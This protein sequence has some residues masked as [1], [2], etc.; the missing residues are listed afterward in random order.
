MR[1]FGSIFLILSCAICSICSAANVDLRTT[2]PLVIPVDNVTPTLTSADVAKV[3]PTDMTSTES[4]SSVM[5]RIADK[6]FNL[7]FNSS[8]MKD[9]TLVRIAEKTQETLKTDVVVAAK[10]PDEV[11]HKFS[12]RVEAF[13]ALAKLEYSGWTKCAVNYDAKASQT[14]V[15]LKEKIFHNKDLVFSH[16]KN[17]SQGLSMIG[18]AWT[19]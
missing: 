16:K 15:E 14:N 8:A 11:S 4:T 12:F 13:Q 1:L 10:N 19:W 3:I 2:K 17:S 18:R 5:T 6:T 7:W 9:T